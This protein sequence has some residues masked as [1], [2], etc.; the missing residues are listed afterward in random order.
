[1]SGR[2]DSKVAIVTGAAAG[3]GAAIAKAFANEGAA[4][5]CADLDGTGARRVA[6]E[7]EVAGGRALAVEMDHSRIA[8]CERTVTATV[9]AF[10]GLD[11]LVNN[12]GIVIFGNVLELTE[13]QW[14]R[15]FRVNVVGPFLMTKAALPELIKRGHSA[16]V[17]MA[18]ASGLRPQR[19]GS[20]YIASKHAIVGLTKSL[21]LDFAGDGVRVNAICPA[22]IRT[23]MA[24]KFWAFRAELQ[25]E[26]ESA[27]IDRTNRQFPL[28]RIGQT[29]DVAAV[30]IHLAS[31]ESRWTTGTTYVLDGGQMLVLG[32]SP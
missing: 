25:G 6:A 30:A 26:P 18:S 3:N 9:A 28:G 8:D 22:V 19:S 13:E 11:V 16:I 5:A 15:Q 1:M 17:M 4:V 2:L 32:T 20:A 27:V 24:E 10:G 23:Q 12:A 31:D 21:A 29:D 7:I 14:E